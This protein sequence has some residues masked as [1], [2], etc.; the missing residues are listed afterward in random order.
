M[1][2]AT[3]VLFLSFSEQ[4]RVNKSF[5]VRLVVLHS[6]AH[7]KCKKLRRYKKKRENEG[8]SAGRALHFYLYAMPTWKCC[9]LSLFFNARQ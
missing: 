5:R 4:H 8:K 9:S 1:P 6:V 3:A 7:L 2:I